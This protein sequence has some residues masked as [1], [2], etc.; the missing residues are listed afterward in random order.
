MRKDLEELAAH[1]RGARPLQHA[2]HLGA[3]AHPPAGRSAHAR[4]GSSTSRSRF[5]MPTRT[6]AERIAGRELGQA[7]A[8]RRGARAGAGL[9]LHRSTS[10][11]TAPTSTA[12]ARSS[13]WRRAGRRPARAGQHAVLRLGTG[14]PRRAHADAGAG[15]RARRRSPRRRSQRYRG[16]MQILFVLP[17]YYEQY[18][19]A[20]YGGW[21]KLYLVVAPDGKALPCHGATQITTLAFPNVR[22]HSLEWIW[23]ESP[24]FKAFR[25]DAWMKEPCRTC[26]RKAVDFGGCRCQAFALTGDAA[27]TDPVCIAHPDRQHHRRGAGRAPSDATDYRYR[28]ARGRAA[29]GVSRSAGHRGRG[30]RPGLRSTSGRSTR[31]TWGRRAGALVGLLGPNGAGK[32]TAMLLLATLLAPSPRPAR[33]LRSRRRRASAAAVRR[34]L[35]LVFQETSVDGLLTVGRTC[36]SPPGWRDSAGGWPRA[37]VADAIERGGLGAARAPGPRASSPAAGG[38]WRTSRA[39][40]CTARSAH[41]RRADRRARSRAPRA[42]VEPA[43]RASGGSTAPRYSSRPTTWPRPSR[44]TGSCCWPAGGSWPDAPAALRASVGDGDGRDRGSGGRARWPGAART[45]AA[46]RAS[47]PSAGCRVGLAGP[48]RAGGRA[49]RRRRR[50]SSRFAMRPADAGG[51]LLRRPGARRRGAGAGMSAWSAV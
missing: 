51:R 11:C 6:I 50:G 37:A 44:P 19:K 30:A 36:S 26:P 33:G 40:R 10:C 21:G 2:G 12:S 42:D 20:C 14:E 22:D 16:K 34:R 43:G 15:R 28:D 49:R 25:G 9:R 48:R 24:A 35:G 13:T 32:T 4:P 45:G 41:P 7:E 29:A 8:R 27:N 17:D 1:A 23:Q 38:G 5:R 39:P 31:W 47:A 18:P 46:A 3:R